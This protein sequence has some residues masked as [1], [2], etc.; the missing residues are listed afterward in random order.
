MYATSEINEGIAE[1]KKSTS[2][3]ARF[4]FRQKIET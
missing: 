2:N 3:N 1:D 4:Y